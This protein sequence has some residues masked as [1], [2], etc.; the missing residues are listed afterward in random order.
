M[1]S[2][3]Y[4]RCLIIL[5]VGIGLGYLLLP[6]KT[7]TRTEKVKELVYIKAKT[8]SVSTTKD[9]VTTVVTDTISDTTSSKDM[10]SYTKTEI[11]KKA[12]M[13]IPY[14]GIGQTQ[15]IYG[16]HIQKDIFGSFGV[17]VGGQYS[18]KRDLIGIAGLSIKF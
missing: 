7:I 17:I 6:N 10:D 15:R 4:V 5:L 8:H 11:N 14:V 12:F 18:T 13:F 2:N 9:G 3:E 16:I 1:W